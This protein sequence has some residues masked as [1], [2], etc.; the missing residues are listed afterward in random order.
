[1]W[2]LYTFQK[3]ISKCAYNE[4]TTIQNK[5]SKA[6]Q[7]TILEFSGINQKY[8]FFSL[9]FYLYAPSG[10]IILKKTHIKYKNI[11]FKMISPSTI[12]NIDNLIVLLDFFVKLG[13]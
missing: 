10:H 2:I 3:T 13:G 12:L 11:D 7:C 4:V 5:A 1:M 9:S 6:Y 8:F